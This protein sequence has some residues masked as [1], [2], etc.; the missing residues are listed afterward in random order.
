MALG[1]GQTYLEAKHKSINGPLTCGKYLNDSKLPMLNLIFN[2]SN[3]GP[4]IKSPC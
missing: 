3:G 1:E 4:S 2:I